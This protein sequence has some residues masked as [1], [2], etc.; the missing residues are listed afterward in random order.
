MIYPHNASRSAVNKYLG[1]VWNSHADALIWVAV[2]AAFVPVLL[3]RDFT[4]NNEGR[5]LIIADEALHNR[6][7]FSFTLHGEPYADKPPLYLWLV[8]LFGQLLGHH[9]MAALGLLSLL[10]ACGVVQRMNVLCRDILSPSVRRTATLMLMTTAYFAGPAMVVRMDMLMCLFIVLALGTFWQMYRAETVSHRHQW[11]MGLWLFLALFTKGPLGLLIPI[12]TIV[13]FAATYRLTCRLGQWLNWRMWLVLLVGCAIWF[14]MAYHEA[15]GSYLYNLLFH[16]TA[17]RGFRAFHHARP[18]YYYL[19]SLWYEWLPWSLLCVAAMV[20]TATRYRRVDALPRF[21]FIMTLT[22]LVL[23]SAISGKLQVYLLPAFPF[24]VYLAAWAM[25]GDMPRRWTLWSLAVPQAV[26][27]LALPALLLA[28][29]L[30]P[31][32]MLMHP[33]LVA[34]ASVLSLSA[35]AAL[36]LLM[37]KADAERSVRVLAFGILAT[38]L[39]GG[40]AMPTLNAIIH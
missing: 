12:V 31:L 34:G 33:W 11:L 15:G 9:N 23:L 1:H 39:L 36:Y 40:M 8:M 2:I 18:F 35:A 29:T 27:T 38:L 13:V 6:H 19:I 24:V 4:P 22:T 32:P 25:M 10:P 3:M 14:T 7:F 37:G 20:F 17:G 16:Q 5:Y 30:A 26:L 21:L 28:P